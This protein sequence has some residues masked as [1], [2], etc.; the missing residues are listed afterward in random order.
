MVVAPAASDDYV[1]Q[2]VRKDPQKSATCYMTHTVSS[3]RRGG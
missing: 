2:T 3:G 1:M